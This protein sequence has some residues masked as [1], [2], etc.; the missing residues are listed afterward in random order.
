MNN[1]CDVINVA[2]GITYSKMEYYVKKFGGATCSF[3][4]NEYYIPG[5]DTAMN[6]VFIDTTS[7]Q[8]ELWRGLTKSF[9][10]P[11]WVVGNETEGYSLFDCINEIHY[12]IDEELG[13]LKVKAVKFCSTDLAVIKK[14]FKKAE[15]AF[16][17]KMKIEKSTEG[18]KPLSQVEG[19]ETL[20]NILSEDEL[21]KF[22]IK[23]L[24]INGVWE[25]ATPFKIQQ[26]LAENYLLEHPDSKFAKAMFYTSYIGDPTLVI[27]RRIEM[28]RKNKAIAKKESGNKDSKRKEA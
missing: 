21:K 22:T 27:D 26:E 11:F 16:E 6:L 19:A 23:S 17:K 3:E 8:Y 24:V 5:H 28:V 18:L 13:K 15:K 25:L 9:F 7:E 12:P 10:D 4:L 1:L 14:K 20:M 2:Y